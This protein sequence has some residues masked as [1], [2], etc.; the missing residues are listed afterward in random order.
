MITDMGENM[1]G[2]TKL[3]PAE[4]EEAKRTYNDRFLALWEKSAPNM[5]RA[6]VIADNALAAGRA[7]PMIVAMPY[8][9][10]PGVRSDAGRSAQHQAFAADLLGVDDR[11]VLMLCD[12]RITTRPYGRSFLESLPPMT[13]AEELQDVEEFLQ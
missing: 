6:N 3:T 11:G 7:Q 1:S 10:T 9:H 2:K 12:P 5:T 13:P 4:W 8:G